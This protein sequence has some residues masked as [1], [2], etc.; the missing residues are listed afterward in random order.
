MLGIGAAGQQ[1]DG[2]VG[3]A[4]LAGVDAAGRVVGGRPAR[5]RLAGAGLGDEPAAAVMH[6]RILHRHLQ[7]PSLAGARTIELW[8]WR[9]SPAPGMTRSSLMSEDNL[10]TSRRA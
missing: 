3:A 1:V 8:P 9:G 4:G 5:R 6:D 2:I 10:I 7:P